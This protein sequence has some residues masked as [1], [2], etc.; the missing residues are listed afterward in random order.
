[1][2]IRFQEIMITIINYPLQNTFPHPKQFFFFVNTI[3]FFSHDGQSVTVVGSSLLG[4]FGECSAMESGSK[5]NDSAVVIF[6]NNYNVNFL[7]KKG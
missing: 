6:I 2:N 1:M 5:I 7:R 4:R 3:N